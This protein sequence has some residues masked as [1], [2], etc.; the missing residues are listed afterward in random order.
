MVVVLS[1]SVIKSTENVTL[2]GFL[3]RTEKTCGLWGDMCRGCLSPDGGVMKTADR[4]GTAQNEA[5]VLF[6]LVQN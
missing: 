4:E 6:S 1:G 5:S 3:W 2:Y